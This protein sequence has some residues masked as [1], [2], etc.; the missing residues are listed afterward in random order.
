MHFAAS[1]FLT[2]LRPGLIALILLGVVGAVPGATVS[3]DEP[4]AQAAS[5]PGLPAPLAAELQDLELMGQR[6]RKLALERLQKL[7][8]TL[9]TSGQIAGQL[10]AAN[11]ECRLMVDDQ[12]TRA[13]ELAEQG[14]VLARSRGAPA[15]EAEFQ[16]CRGITREYSGKLMQ[17]LEDYERAVSE[18]LRLGD[19]RLLAL[20]LNHRGNLRAYLGDHARALPDL[21]RAY[22]LVTQL[23]DRRLMREVLGNIAG[24]YTRMGETDKS[25]EYFKQLLADQ[26]AA[27]LPIAVADTQFNIART[28]EGT[29]DFAQALAWFERSHTT[30]LETN[31][32]LS[33]AFADLG[34]GLMLVNL[35]RHAEGLER[36]KLAELVFR[37][38]NDREMLARIALGQGKALLALGDRSTGL[39]R[40]LQAR[41]AFEA[42]GNE[43]Y[44]SQALSALA[45]ALA[46]QGDMAAAFSAAQQLVQ[47]RDSL[48][49][50]ERTD[51]TTRLRIQ[52]D[53]E[54]TEAENAALQKQNELADQALEATRRVRNWQTAAIVLALGLLGV[55]ALLVKRQVRLARQMQALA[56]TD[57]LTGLPNRRHIVSFGNQE[58]GLQ[59]V[60]SVLVFDVDHFKRIND[61][62][63]HAVGDVV[64]KRLARVCQRE[65]RQS[66]RAGRT[67][68]EEFLVVLPTAPMAVAARIGDKLRA[69]VAAEAWGEIVPDLQVTISV[70]VAE[71]RAGE[72][73]VM[74]VAQRAD[75]ALYRAKVNGR[76]RVELADEVP[77][78]FSPDASAS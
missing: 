57:E 1:A 62:H 53:S 5:S 24:A 59:P 44:L 63:G 67:G 7:I 9:N 55:L 14:M 58:L 41:T 72:A 49:R 60:L 36:L 68:G 23:N 25:L 31:D 73:Q 45:P 77:S 29:G 35:K 16:L 34:A 19:T 52:F 54:K 4:A 20:G 32:R 39:Q 43:L 33:V 71:R 11:L 51:A 64:L 18:G 40:L 46:A 12:P 48:Q 56:L 42:S 13:Q 6:D 21:Q 37:D 10:R 3:P 8:P 66:D 2:R 78:G 70:G 61:S 15:A 22:Q 38:A 50:K 76:N 65:L 75:A 26:Q 17:G 47:V 27:R 69:A 74:R 30:A 28:L